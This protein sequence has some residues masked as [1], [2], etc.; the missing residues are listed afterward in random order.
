M[1]WFSKL[2]DPIAERYRA[3]TVPTRIACLA[4]AVAVLTG[5]VMLVGGRAGGP[6]QPLFEGRSFSFRELA[7]MTTAFQAAGLREARLTDGQILVPQEKLDAYLVALD[8]ADALPAD[9]DDSLDAVAAES[10]PFASRQ[11]TELGYRVAEQKK[12]ARIL[13]G[14]NGI[15]TASVQYAEVKKPG[16]PP[17]SDVRAVVA[18]RATGNR[19]LTYEEIEAVRDTVAGFVAGLDRDQVTISDLNACRAYPGGDGPGSAGANYAARSERARL[20]E[21]FRAKIQ[22]RLTAY[23]GLIVGVN[24]QLAEPSEVSAAGAAGGGRRRL[25]P[26]LV[27]ASIDL[28]KS[29]FAQV[30][31]ERNGNAEGTSLDRQGLQA[32]E[33]DI[34]Q[35]VEQAVLALL[36]SPA[37]DLRGVP[38]VVVTSYDAP[39]RI[40]TNADE[41]R[42]VAAAW[43]MAHWSLL[44]AGGVLVASVVLVVCGRRRSAPGASRS[45][46]TTV[47]EAA[48]T[49]A[50]DAFVSSDPK[51]PATGPEV[52]VRIHRAI[53]ENPQAAAETLQRWL[54][55]AA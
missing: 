10:S 46:E 22:N 39:P 1:E 36:P 50:S 35:T 45:Q 12:L 9:F 54:R 53:Q 16:F 19:E 13:S 15:E 33:E 18:V 44:A 30:W 51:A 7:K 21:E 49:L 40:E 31:R 37:A 43:I 55:K 14:M 2:A 24:V 17:T 28:P 38:Q 27:S 4:L 23:P 25:E 20:E 8:A 3:L 26:A 47:A 34:K 11:Q 6:Y 5:L 52:H 48:S 41:L 29:Y 42:S 32:I